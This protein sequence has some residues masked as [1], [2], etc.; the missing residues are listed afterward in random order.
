MSLP[1]YPGTLSLPI[2]GNREP[3]TRPVQVLQIASSAALVSGARLAVGEVVALQVEGLSVPG[4]VVA[5]ERVRDELALRLSFSTMPEAVQAELD[6]LVART[7]GHLGGTV[8]GQLRAALRRDGVTDLREIADAHLAVKQEQADNLLFTS[9]LYTAEGSDTEGCILSA[10]VEGEYPCILWSLNLYLGLNR[11]PRVI[12]ATR[13]ATERFGT[14]SGTSAASGGLNAMHQEIAA[15]I[16][17]MVG[18]AETMLFPTGYTANLGALST[19]PGPKDL[20]LMDAE[21]HASMFDGAKMSGRTYLTFRHNDVADLARKL[22]RAQGRHDNVIV[23]VESAYSMS[24]DLAPLVEIAAL[25]DDHD[26]L[27]YVDEAHTFGFYGS[28]GQGW[29]HVQGV[30]DRV[31]FIMSTLSK[32]TASAGGF[33]ATSERFCALL[34]ATSSSY[35]F[36]ACFTPPNAATILASLDEIRFHAPHRRR[37]HANNARMRAA[38]KA[39]GFDLGTSASPIIPVYVPDISKLYRLTSL[40]QADGVFSVPVT[41]PAVRPNEGRIRFIVNARHT[42]A[43]I[44]QTVATLAAHARTLGVVGGALDA[45]EPRLKPRVAETA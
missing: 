21:C 8:I 23:V 37:L 2:V 38:L 31:D 45:P 25:K 24:G 12:A 13:A 7:Y 35:I 33:V 11:E 27:L 3:D 26:F 41:Y 4:L 39:E 29:C 36:Q 20:L 19:L 5:H 9:D 34:R 43:Q 1:R 22:D 32:A 14:G 16:S 6:A 44:D 17:Q 15:T 40:L 18:K 42:S 10:S 28:Q 30:S